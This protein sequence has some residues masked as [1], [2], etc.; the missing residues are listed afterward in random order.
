MSLPFH[1]VVFV[2]NRKNVTRIR[3]SATLAANET[4]TLH[5]LPLGPGLMCPK[6]KSKYFFQQCWHWCSPFSA[7]WPHTG[8][9]IFETIFCHK[10]TKSI[11]LKH[12]IC[13]CVSILDLLRYFAISPAILY[14]C[15]FCYL[16]NL[17]RLPDK[18]KACASLHTINLMHNAYSKKKHWI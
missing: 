1:I 7:T 16:M 17:K 5:K 14:Y 3:T 9:I 18:I 10:N 4:R 8:N 6:L 13:T 2:K 11:C 15:C 12:W